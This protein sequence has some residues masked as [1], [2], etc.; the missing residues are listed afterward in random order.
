MKKKLILG[1]S[2]AISGT[3]GCFVMY[4][5]CSNACKVY[6]NAEKEINEVKEKDIPKEEK[7]EER[8]D[9]L[10]ER[11]KLDRAMDAAK[12]TATIFAMVSTCLA[13]LVLAK[14]IDN[15]E[16]NLST[17][18]NLFEPGKKYSVDEVLNILRTND[19]YFYV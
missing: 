1:A 10:E 11:E 15:I 9:R 2:I 16:A 5:S 14:R 6:K 8:I 13:L 17:F 7:N 19:A 4:K 12:N 3:I 18:D